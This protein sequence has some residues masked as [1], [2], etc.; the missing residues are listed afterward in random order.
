MDAFTLAFIEALFFTQ[1]G[2]NEG[3]LGD[4]GLSEISTELMEKIEKDCAEFQTKAD[5]LIVDENCHYTGCPIIVY[6]GHDFLLTRNGHG[7]GY[8]DGDWTEPAGTKLTDLAK[9]FGMMEVYLGDDGK[10]YAM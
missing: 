8:T 2:N 4:A 5:G 1:S 10:V 9:S 3:E 7:C 6:A